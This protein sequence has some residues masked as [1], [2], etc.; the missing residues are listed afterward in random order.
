MVAMRE[1]SETIVKLGSSSIQSAAEVLARAFRGDP[2]NQHFY[3]DEGVRKSILPA[4]FEYRV[5]YGILYGEVHATSELEGIAIWMHS[6]QL[7]DSLWRDIR[8]GGSK[9]YRQTPGE[10]MVRMRAVQSYTSERRE[11]FAA[12]PYWILGPLGVDPPHQRKGHASRLIRHMLD[13]LDVIR[14]TAFLQTQTEGNLP[15]Y[16]HLGFEIISTGEI[17]DT[18]ISHWDMLRKPK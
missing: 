12:E 4:F 1:D 7:K 14:E 13:R 8:A 18:G 2:L 3:P 11:Q 16:E 17:P 10:M 15:L 5:K 9:V 6:A